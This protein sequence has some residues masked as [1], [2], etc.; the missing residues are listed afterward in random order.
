MDAVGCKFEQL[1]DG[2][3]AAHD[4]EFCSPRGQGGIMVRV[5]PDQTDELIADGAATIVEMRGRP[6]RGWL[7]VAPERLGEAREL[8]RW[9]RRG[10]DYAGSLEPKRSG[11]SG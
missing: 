2:G 10:V 7:R 4:G 3:G 1:A 5:D 11:R 9:V 8:A 6:M